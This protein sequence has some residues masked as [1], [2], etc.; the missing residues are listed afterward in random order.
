MV[1]G[2]A[3]DGTFHWPHTGIVRVLREAAEGRAKAG[4]LRL[5][6]ARAW[7]GERHPEQVPEKY[8][9]TTWPQVLSESGCFRLEYRD[10]DA[11]RVAWYRALR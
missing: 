9:C 1:N 8:G 10:G 6:E 5:D 4:W 11:G 2:I 3:P 7:I